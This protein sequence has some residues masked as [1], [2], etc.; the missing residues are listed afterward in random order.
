MPLI[1]PC[2]DFRS[3]LHFFPQNL[4]FRESKCVFREPQLQKIPVFFPVSRE[5]VRRKVSARL[6]PPPVSLNRREVPPAFPTKYAKDAHISRFFNDKPNRRER[7][8]PQQRTSL[9]RF[10]S[11]RHTCSPVS[12][13]VLGE[14]NA[15]RSW[16]SGKNEWTSS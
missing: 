4:Q 16:G 2:S 1:I 7:T 3:T 15:I 12:S 8:P 9:S 13:R 6:R 5:F 10:F 11:G 14:C